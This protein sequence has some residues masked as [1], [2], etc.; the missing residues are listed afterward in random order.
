MAP[1]AGGDVSNPQPPDASAVD[2]ADAEPKKAEIHIRVHYPAA[3]GSMTLRGSVA[4][5]S[6]D[7]DLPLTKAGDDLWTADLP[8]ETA[9]E[10]KPMFTNTWSRGPNYRAKPGATVDIYPRFVQVA[11]RVEKRFPNFTSAKLSVAR[12]VWVYFPPSYEENTSARFPVV[13]MHDGQNLFDAALA[14]GGVEWRIDEAMNQ[15]AE[16]GS[17]RE[18]IVVGVGNT[19]ERMSE[20]T[21]VADP[22]YG[23]GNGDTYLEVL[24]TELKPLVDRSL[25]TLP[26]R[27]NTGVMG[28]SLGGLI[29]AQAGIRRSS[30]F[31]FVGVFSPS[32]WWNDRWLAGQVKN[33][34]APRPRVYLDSGNAGASNDD[35]VNTRALADEYRKSGYTDGPEFKYVVQDGATHSE[36]YWAERAPAALA[37][38]L[39]PG[40]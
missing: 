21:P 6:W 1:D 18:A 36:R 23:G 27:A 28:S 19:R 24:Q 9:L 15:G 11:G 14:F 8:I 26:D 20:Y 40:R 16:D 30:T 17:I 33:T 13:Y 7:R 25:R 22:T 37:F 3:G 2:A 34:M 5:L 39:G 32:A 38:L 35:V 12:D 31:G 29:S 10:F 4:P